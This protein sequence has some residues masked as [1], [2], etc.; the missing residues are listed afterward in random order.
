MKKL[1]EATYVSLSRRSKPITYKS[2]IFFP[3]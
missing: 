2:N 1:R 3:K